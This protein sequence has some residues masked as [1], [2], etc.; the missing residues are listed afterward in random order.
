MN[1]ITANVEITNNARQKARKFNL[2]KK[3]NKQVGFLESNPRHNSLNF[4]PLESAHG[5]W[6]F[7]I[8]KHF[9]GLVIKTSNG[10]RVYDVIKHP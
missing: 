4:K 3:F 1:N 9:W 8:D 5:I 10:L 6:R 2:K 7:R